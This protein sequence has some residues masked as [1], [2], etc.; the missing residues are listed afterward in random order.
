MNFSPILKNREVIKAIS[1]ALRFDGKSDVAAWQTEARAKLSDLLGLGYIDK[2]DPEFEILSTS[3]TDAYTE[4]CFK[5]QSESNFYFTSTLRVPSGAS[6]KLPVAICLKGSS[7]DLLAALSDDSDLG[8]NMCTRALN[9]GYCAMVVETRN[10]D[11]CFLAHDL[12]PEEME[13]RVTWC[14]CYRSSMRSLMLS[15]TTTG[16][17]VWDLM[18]AIDA[19]L[20]HFDFVDETAITLIGNNACASVAYYAAAIDERIS[21]VAVTGGVCSYEHSIIAN[22]LCICGYIPNISNYFEMGDIG[23]LI[24]PRKLVVFS[25]KDDKYYPACGVKDAFELTKVVYDA[26]GASDN[27]KMQIMDE[28]A[29]FYADEAW[30]ELHK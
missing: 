14:A 26:L 2:C 24:A 18:C 4:Y 3:T 20:A 11:E 25:N 5:L 13:K 27:C 30:K 21:A 1:P 12:I 23:G 17:R 19:L 10:F 15:R 9:E 7:D 8:R 16:E 29:V 28:A 22:N 6:G